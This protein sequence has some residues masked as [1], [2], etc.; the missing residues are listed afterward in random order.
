MN[1]LLSVLL[2]TASFMTV[3]S[4][5]SCK[6]QQK[7]EP[8]EFTIT[9][10]NTELSFEAAVPKAVTYTVSTN[11]ESWDAVSSSDWVTVDKSSDSFTIRCKA[12]FETADREPATVT[13]TSGDAAPVEITV[14]QRGLR[15]WM[16]GNDNNV[17]SYWVNGEKNTIPGASENTSPTDIYVSEN[18]EVHIVGRVGFGQYFYS[19]Y[20]SSVS[21][22]KDITG[23]IDPD[24]YV[25]AS[26]VYEDESTHDVYYTAYE[27]WMENDGSQTVVAY[28]YKNDE[29]I[30]ITEDGFAT[31]GDIIVKD[32]EVCVQVSEAANGSWYE[33]GGVRTNLEVIGESINPSCMTIHGNDVYV[34]GF[35]LYKDGENYYYFPCYWINGKAVAINAEETSQVYAIYV[36]DEGNVYTAGSEGSGWDR[37]AAYWKN[38]EITRLT[39]KNNA[40][41]SGI[42]AADGH[43]LAGGFEKSASGSNVIVKTW[44]DGKETA[45]TDGSTSCYV[46][47]MF[48][49]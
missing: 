44:L 17:G 15:V 27:G 11:A 30:A 24:N 34:G 31:P 12:N 39:E 22:W 36:D 13:V 21:G 43:V 40:C 7:H 35:Y 10:N 48:V 37:C 45:W 49:R 41:L 32:G 20:Y 1:K 2:A 29:R 28:Y 18:G 38:G 33:K 5:S 26:S 14:T 25:A 16:T 6:E 3:A 8:T 23:A 9:P 42:F 19:F 46:E 47:E 4:L